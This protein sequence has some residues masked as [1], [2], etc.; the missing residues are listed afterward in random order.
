MNLLSDSDAHRLEQA[1][2]IIVYIY[3]NL[4]AYGYLY[5]V[6]SVAHSFPGVDVIFQVERSFN[7]PSSFFIQ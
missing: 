6:N 4:N 2:H 7:S 1:S 3:I 5:L